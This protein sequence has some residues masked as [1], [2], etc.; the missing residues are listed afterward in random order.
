MDVGDYLSRQGLTPLSPEEIRRTIVHSLTSEQREEYEQMWENYVNC[1][2][3][4]STQTMYRFEYGFVVPEFQHSLYNL[5][6]RAPDFLEFFDRLLPVLSKYCNGKKNVLDCGCGDAVVLG[7]LAAEHPDTIFTGIDRVPE[8][9][10]RAEQRILNMHAT[11]VTVRLGDCYDRSGDPKTGDT[12]DGV[13][14]INALDDDREAWSTFSDARFDTVRKLSS[15]HPLLQPQG[16]VMVSLT[17]FP[18]YTEEFESLLRADF[19]RADF[20]VA[21]ADSFPYADRRHYW[22]TLSPATA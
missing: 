2:D 22:W 6:S 11:N 17:P 1:G 8:A 12:F 9:I 4:E 18:R 7:Y 3:V 13:L 21:N 5:R 20:A 10:T 15:L 16:T 19:S 14:V